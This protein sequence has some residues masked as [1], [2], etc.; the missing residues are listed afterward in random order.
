RGE[1]VSVMSVREVVKSHWK[2]GA[3]LLL[4]AVSA[5]GALQVYPY[6]VASLGAGAVA[7]FAAARNILNALNVLAQAGI[8]Y[9]PL[10]SKRIFER[11]GRAGLTVYLTRAAVGMAAA[12][13][14]FCIAASFEATALLHW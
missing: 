13:I 12:A 3:W 1:P 2:I 8:N 10:A 7:A 4:A 14:L 5:Y 11:E 6:F 9:F